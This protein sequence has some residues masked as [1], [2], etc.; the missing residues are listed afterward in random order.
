MNRVRAVLLIAL[1]I[2]PLALAIGFT[3]WLDYRQTVSHPSADQLLIWVVNILA[4][5]AIAAVA[6]RYIVLRGIASRVEE[7]SSAVA[8]DTSARGFL[9]DR[10]QFPSFPDRAP[11]AREI[12]FMG[13]SLEVMTGYLYGNLVDRVQRGTAF[14]FVLVDPDS[15][16]VSVCA[17]SLFTIKTPADLASDIQRTI[18]RIKTLRDLAEQPEIIELRLTKHAP[19]YSLVAVEPSASDGSLIVELYPFKVSSIH[20]PHFE[21]VPRDHPW[22]SFF[23]AQYDAVW[24]NSRDY[25]DQREDA[26]TV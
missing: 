17:E 9:L 14:R 19:G 6:Q 25:F 12:W 21:L 7:V 1:E 16:A 26:S 22:F 5:L 18:A 4:L 15:P 11:S 10:T 23:R 13:T 20:R 8:D 2:L 24:E 3:A